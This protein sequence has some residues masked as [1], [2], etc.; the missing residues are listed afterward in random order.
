VIVVTTARDGLH[1]H[2]PQWRDRRQHRSELTDAA[3]GTHTAAVDRTWR[4]CRCALVR[5]LGFSNEINVW[6]ENLTNQ[7]YAEF[8]NATFF[9]PEP[10]RTAK[11]SYRVKF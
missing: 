5:T 8:S 10:G 6:V 1:G 11:I 7:L 4:R 2:P 9:R 3:G